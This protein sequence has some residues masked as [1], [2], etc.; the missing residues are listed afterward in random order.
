MENL[1]LWGFYILTFYAFLPGLVSRTFGFRVFKKGRVEREIALTF[2]D[3]PDPV[4]TPRLLDL[5]KRY[6]AKAT[7]FVVGVH[8]EQNPEILER[9]HREGHIIGIH[10][11]VHKTNWLMRPK[12][13]RKQIHR[14]SDIVKKAT[15]ERP[16]YYRPP[17]GIVNLFDFSNLGYLQIIL[18]SAMFGDWRIRLGADRL[19]KRMMRKLAPGEVLLLHDCGHTFG[20]DADAPQN[21]LIA[22]ER[23]LEEGTRRGYRF[24]AIDEMIRLTDENKARE[25]GPF[26]RLIVALWLLYEKAFHAVFRLKPVGGENPTFH[27]RVRTYAG[28]HVDMGEGRQLKKGDTIVEIHFDNRMLQNIASH[29]GPPVHTAIRLL[30]EMEKA[31]PQMMSQIAADPEAENA[32]AM[33]GVTMIHR[34][35][36]RFGFQIVKLEKGWFDRMTRLYL[37]LLMRVLTPKKKGNRKKE[38][39]SE[40]I[41]PHM[42]VMTMDRVRQM[43]GRERGGDSSANTQAAPDKLQASDEAM[44]DAPTVVNSPSAI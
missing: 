30:R 21:M 14:T 3:G 32:R 36:D 31:I 15:G 35:A 33:V 40:A 17:W 16:A 23:Y 13:V 24:V 26:K 19:T 27:Y 43:T 39:G 18:W 28:Q 34:G 4:Y 29:G 38:R 25:L 6:N 11:Y 8:A 42:L 20:A 22:L 44:G 12:S 1:L 9:M 41:N 10:N 5:L 2:D 7:F 37:R